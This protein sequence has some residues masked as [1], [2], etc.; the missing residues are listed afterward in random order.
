MKISQVKELI[1]LCQVS[2]VT[3][4]LTA[5]SGVGKTSILKQI[6]KD[7]NFDRTIVLRPSLIS[8]VGDLVGLPD[9][10][11]IPVETTDGKT[12][13]ILRTTFASP[14][15]LPRPE[16][17]CLVI[18]DEINRSNKD[19]IM[20]MF[21]LI[22]A[23]HPKIGQY[24][25]PEGCMVVATLNPPS[26]DY[27]GVLDFSD[28]AFISRLC[29]IEIQPDLE[30][31]IAWGRK[32]N[33][34][35][36]GTMN[37]YAK[38]K[39]EFFKTGKPFAVEEFGMKIDENN[40]SKKKVNDLYEAAKKLGT[41]KLVRFEAIRGMGGKEFATRYT[42]FM[43]NHVNEISIE[44]VLDDPTTVTRIDKGKMDFI[45]KLNGD[46]E[47]KLFNTELTPEQT[48]NVFNYLDKVLPL[49]TLNG[50][51]Q[52]L[53]KDTLKKDKVNK[54]LGQIGEGHPILEKIKKIEL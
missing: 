31:F 5:V 46:L 51:L 6:G 42:Q 40:R 29:F 3:P 47:H 26:E 50:F 22:E 15:W 41:N 49:D 33:N 1:T 43:D 48:E 10:K 13:T 38:N 34:L 9:L 39:V 52:G 53:N 2:K 7:M 30:D 28:S 37:F 14:D 19:V 21:D 4:A 45:S 54:F 11:T 44:D 23:D 8:D 20:A 17:K 36:D 35:S 25:L 27:S 18:V 16:E 12:D 24:E 32:D